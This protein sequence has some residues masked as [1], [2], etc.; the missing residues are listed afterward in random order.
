MAKIEIY[1]PA[2]SGDPG[3]LG[4]SS[5][6][7]RS[8]RPTFHNPHFSRPIAAL[9]LFLVIALAGCA[10]QFAPSGGPV[11]KSPP[12]IIF[13]SPSQKEL[14]FTSKKII[15]RFDKYMSQR[16]V[17]SAI[18]FPPLTLSE[19][20]FDWSGKELTINLMKRLD[21]NRTYI[22]TIGAT[23]IDLRNNYLGRAYN[24]VF[25]TGNKID[26]GIVNGRIYGPKPQPYTV[27]AFPVTAYIDT[28]RPSMNLAKYVT[29]SD[30][31]GSYVL[32]G[33]ADGKYRLICFDDQMRN[34]TYAPQT[35]LYASATHDID[36]SR[37]APEVNDVDFIPAEE[38][39]S[40]PQLYGVDLAKD[41]LIVLKFSESID[42]SVI[43]PSDFVVRDSATG[44]RIPVGFAARLEANP[45]D[46]V[47]GTTAPLP[48]KRKYF[49][50]AAEDL[51]DIYY[52][53]MSPENNTTVL[54]ADSA[55]M[56]LAPY[57]FNF[58]DSTRGI[59]SYDTLFCQFILPLTR[60]DSGRMQVS[61]HD[62]TGLELHGFIKRI[63]QTIFRIVTS[64]LNS[65]EWYTAK[66]KYPADAGGTG[67]DEQGNR[68]S[69]VTRHFRTID[70]GDLGDIEGKVTPLVSGKNI[71]VSATRTDGKRFTCF[72]DKN[73][74]YKLDG[75]L[76]GT[77]TVM[78]YVQHDS[79]STYFSGESYP[80][81]FAEPFGVYQEPIKVRARWTTDGV[82]IRLY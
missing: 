64:G 27:A 75:I 4:F 2:T 1:R 17:E 48:L 8:D 39:T 54:T 30:D 65:S 33:L 73:G 43:R 3:T 14:N 70:S 51:T 76:A 10:G 57:Y 13:S 29:Q 25:S 37:E 69:V 18:Y 32:Q 49:I 79:V 50:K 16:S 46:V 21:T 35:D 53:R 41:G 74:K 77:Y 5:S 6:S 61:L 34:F 7:Q 23:A 68:D 15:L 80:Y 42:T 45:Y 58:Q 40:R 44:E 78:A 26:T 71:V 63:S 31:S 19:M 72:A 52:N 28:L 59:T 22:L 55:T 9:S 24:L 20:S 38:D 62:S 56:S 60:L 67:S 12:K 36:I 47:I 11:D 81:Q 66:L 82:L